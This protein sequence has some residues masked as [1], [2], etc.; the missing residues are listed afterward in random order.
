MNKVTEI[1]IR[2]FSESS[3]DEIMALENK[4]LIDEEIDSL[5]INPNVKQL[6]DLGDCCLHYG[7]KWVEVELI[8]GEYVDI[9]YKRY[10]GTGQ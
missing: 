2:N 10:S 3:V 7:C 9:F 5:S 6:S 1:K 4:L 8:N